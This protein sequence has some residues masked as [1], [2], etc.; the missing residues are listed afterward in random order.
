MQGQCR[1]CGQ[2]SEG[3]AFDKWVKSTFTDFDKLQGG[4]IVCNACCFS[5]MKPAQN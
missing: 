2:I 1:F 5:S 4:E 3:V